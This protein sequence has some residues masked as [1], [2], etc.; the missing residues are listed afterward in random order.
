MCHSSASKLSHKLKVSFE[1]EQFE[2][3]CW[4]ALSKCL[5]VR[6]FGI[7]KPQRTQSLARIAVMR[8]RVCACVPPIHVSVIKSMCIGSKNSWALLLLL[9]PFLFTGCAFSFCH[10]DEGSATVWL[11]SAH[12]T[13]AFAE[14]EIANEP[15]TDRQKQQKN[16]NHTHSHNR[17][18]PTHG[19]VPKNRV[20]ET[21]VDR[22]SDKNRS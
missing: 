11:L 1:N 6:I 7:S 13:V 8:W 21:I 19:H 18:A 15:H 16:T 4:K 2:M 9:L 5:A 12:N 10:V 17:V 22:S 3:S 20:E 14:G